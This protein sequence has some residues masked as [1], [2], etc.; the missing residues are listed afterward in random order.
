MVQR[1]QK[2][3]KTGIRKKDWQKAPAKN[4]K[5]KREITVG[6]VKKLHE[7]FPD[8][9]VRSICVDRYFLK[10][11][12]FSIDKVYDQ[13]KYRYITATDLKAGALLILWVRRIR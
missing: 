11:F 6:L 13:E 4:T 2:A 5:N 10:K 1:R 8:F 12:N 3:Q 9:K 7:H